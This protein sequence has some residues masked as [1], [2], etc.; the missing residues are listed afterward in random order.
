MLVVGLSGVATSFVIARHGG[1]FDFGLKYYS[2]V[3][4][5]FMMP[6][7]LGMVYRRTPWWSGMASC[8]ASF[9]TTFGLIALDA[10][11]DHVYERNI[12]SAILASTAVF[13][14]SAWF[15][16]ADDPASAEA[17]KLDLDLRTPVPE[18]SG[19]KLSGSLAV[20]GVIGNLSLV[21]GAVLLA[22]TFLP[23][24]AQAPA[25]INLIAGLMLIG[26]GF[27]L[28]KL[29]TLRRTGG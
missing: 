9:A 2:I 15:Y 22:C 3:G 8:I 10:W 27:G 11:P 29:A 13:A 23:A 24:S 26:I 14:L 12:L 7:L 6:V 16:R 21:L 18:E 28:R 17:Q 19:R 25:G 1:A 20:Y 5:G 4:P